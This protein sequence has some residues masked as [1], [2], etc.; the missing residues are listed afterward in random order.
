MFRPSKLESFLS[1][2]ALTVSV[3]GGL[4]S[5]AT[6][7]G[8]QPPGTAS[9]A[10]S[11]TILSRLQLIPTPTYTSPL[12]ANGRSPAQPAGEQTGSGRF[13]RRGRL[14]IRLGP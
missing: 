7:P 4:S 9:P 6:G 11:P 8:V 3:S 2:L 1:A 5:A 12:Y 14:D 10:Q 13:V